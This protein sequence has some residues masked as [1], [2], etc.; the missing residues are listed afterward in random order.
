[1]VRSTCASAIR[2]LPGLGEPMELLGDG[3]RSAIHRPNQVAS[4]RTALS[5]LRE[6]RFGWIN[7]SNLPSSSG[8]RPCPSNPIRPQHNAWFRSTIKSSGSSIPTEMRISVGVIPSRNR[9]CSGMS[10]WVIAA[11]CEASVSVPPR[12]TASLI[13]LRRSR[14]AKAS[15]PPLHFEAE[16]GARAPA[17]ALEDWTIGMALWQEP[18]IPDRRDLRMSI[19]EGC[20]LA[21][22]FRSGRHSELQGL[23]G[24]H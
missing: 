13:T 12:L 3:P 22:A 21:R 5:T 24:A 20:D 6:H 15:A 17:L 11:G 19:E 7:V 16:S 1:M 2:A 8:D 14:T 4:P 18:Q 23:E 10:E 9:S